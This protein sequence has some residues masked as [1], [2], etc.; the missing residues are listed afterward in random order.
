MV[1]SGFHVG[2][3]QQGITCSLDLE[4]TLEFKVEKYLIQKNE[5]NTL[6]T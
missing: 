2:G 1:I 3:E 6:S 4:N 5:Y